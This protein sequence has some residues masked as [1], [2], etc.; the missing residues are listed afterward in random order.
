MFQQV[1][2]Q[3][4]DAASGDAGEHSRLLAKDASGKSQAERMGEQARPFYGMPEALT[5]FTKTLVG[6][7]GGASGLKDTGASTAGEVAGRMVGTAAAPLLGPAAPAGPAIGGAVGS[8]VG[9]AAGRTLQGKD[10]SAKELA[11]EAFFSVLPEAVL[12]PLSAIYRKT[13]SRTAKGLEATKDLAAEWL[14][15]HGPSAFQPKEKK[16]LDTAYDIIRG[17]GAMVN[18]KG[19]ASPLEA[20]RS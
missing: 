19:I 12:K 11:Q 15:K 10:V 6:A 9:L 4:A 20:L 17:S 18:P 14:L 2:G 1:L 16:V 5:G 7:T 13:L 8:A 3:I